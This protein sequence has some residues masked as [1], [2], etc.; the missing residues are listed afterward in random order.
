M[1]NSI[2][3]WSLPPG[4]T[5]RDIDPPEQPCHKCGKYDCVCQECLVCGSY[6]CLTHETHISIYARLQILRMQVQAAE[7]ELKL[8]G[9]PTM[10]ADLSPAQWNQA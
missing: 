7:V 10:P 6:G 2:F 5:M 8:R 1:P 9:L 3:G 4:V